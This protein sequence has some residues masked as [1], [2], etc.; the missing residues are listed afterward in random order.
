M[1]GVAKKMEERIVAV[2][3]RCCVVDGSYL[4]FEDVR[5]YSDMLRESGSMQMRLM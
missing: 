1:K 5:M 3:G 4:M 2:C